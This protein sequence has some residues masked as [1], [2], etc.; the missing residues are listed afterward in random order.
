MALD[1]LSQQKV[2]EKRH[3]FT[4]EFFKIETSKF[5][6]P[7]SFNFSVFQVPNLMLDFLF[8][9]YSNS[10]DEFIFSIPESK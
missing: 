4:T 2:F 8:R 3:I 5:T 7:K 10:L 6:F 1:F 9:K